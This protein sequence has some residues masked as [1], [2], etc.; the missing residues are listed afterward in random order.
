MD[1]GRCRPH[2]ASLRE[3]DIDRDLRLDAGDT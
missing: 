1:I 3:P 2:R